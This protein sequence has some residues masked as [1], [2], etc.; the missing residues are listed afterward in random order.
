M[1]KSDFSTEGLP[2]GR[3]N[4]NMAYLY[5][6][7]DFFTV[8]FEDTDVVNLLLEATSES[9]SNIYSRFLQLTSSLSLNDIQTTVGSSIELLLIRSS[10]LVV[11]ELNTFNISKKIVSTRYVANKPMLPTTL[12]ESG[13][14]FRIEPDSTNMGYKVAF[15]KSIDSFAFPTRLLSDGVTKEYA[16]WF[17]DAEIDEQLISKYYGRLIDVPAAA[18]TDLFKNFVYGLYYVYNQGPVLS[19]IRKG[20]NLALGIPLAR[21]N[22]TVL[23]VRNYIDTDLYIVITDKNQ[24]VVPY[25]IYPSVVPDQVLSVSDEIAQ[26]VEIKDWIEYDEWWVNMYIPPSV[27][28][29]LPTGQLDRH[30]SA[31]SNFDY[32]MREYIKKN[33]FLVNVKVTSFKNNQTFTQL[34]EIINR[35]KPSYTQPIYVWTIPYLDETLTLNDDILPQRRDYNRPEDLSQPIGKMVRNNLR[36]LSLPEYNALGTA[37]FD[38]TGLPTNNTLPTDVLTRGSPMF[39]RMNIPSRVSTLMGEGYPALNIDGGVSTGFVNADSQYKNTSEVDAGWINTLFY[40]GESTNRT[41]RS[42]LSF[43]R[44]HRLT[45]GIPATSRLM[46]N[47]VPADRRVIPM[48]VINETALSAKCIT[49]GLTLPSRSVWVFDLLLGDTSSAINSLPIN[50]AN[51]PSDYYKLLVD[52]FATLFSRTGIEVPTHPLLPDTGRRVWVPSV[53]SDITSG[54]YII[55]VR[56][57]DDLIGLYY[58]TN[59]NTLFAPAYDT[60][61]DIDSMVMTMSAPISR[62]M[63]PSASPYYLLR[64]RGILN[65]NNTYGNTSSALNEPLTSPTIENNYTDSMNLIPVVVNRSGTILKHYIST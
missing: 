12:L 2:I 54:D 64:G 6:L 21:D 52:N 45:H 65:Y 4:A 19:L 17:V 47:L 43:T 62:G 55:A 23:D 34:A 27:I 20:L 63:G 49:M 51:N 22:E 57:M 61:K 24:Y 28:P 29:S 36:T 15:S 26:W 44:G 56:I 53:V 50:G 16:L 41:K 25:G 30:A 60:I 59:N 39:I 33:T 18:S 14:D 31:G 38:G 10:D 11:G 37:D 9:A 7:S 1:I 42:T 40:R 32:L 35:V 8:M 3:N 5:G 13:V 48:Y 46:S 58:I